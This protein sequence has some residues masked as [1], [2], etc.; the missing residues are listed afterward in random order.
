M[1]K[2]LKVVAVAAA[3]VALVATGLGAVGAIS[4]TTAAAISGIASVVSAVAS[5]GSQ[6][7][8]KPPPTRGSETKIQVGIEPPAPYIMGEAYSAGILRH[9]TA[10][11]ATL[12]KVPNP[13]RAMV[14]VASVAGP[15]A[16]C[17]PMA[18]FAAIG[19]YYTGFLYTDTQLGATPEAT[20]LTPHFAGMP[21]WDS[22][23]KLS[24]QAAILWNL[25][26]DKD[27]K[28]FASGLPN[29]GAVWQGVKVYDPREDS[30]YPGGSGAQRIDDESTWEYS[31]NPALHAIAY[32]YG[33]YQ[34]GKKVFGIGQPVEGIDLARF[35]AWANVCDANEWRLSGTIYEPGD[36]WA[37]LKD[38]MAAGGAEP[39]ATGGV[40]SVRYRAPQTSLATVTED[41]I[42]DDDLSITAMQTY[43]A[44]VNG[45]VPKYR[46]PEHN[47]EFVS[48]EKVSIPTYV[49]EDG[50]EK[51]EERQW[52]LVRDVDQAAQLASYAL[53]DARELGPIE[54]TLKPQ[55]RWV[56]PGVCL[57]LDLPSLD[58]D[59]DAIVLQRE[60]DPATMK[61]KLTLIGETAGKHDYALGLTGTPPP[62]PALGQTA[63]ERDELAAAAGDPVGYVTGLISTSFVTDADPADGLIQGT[64]TSLTVEDHTRSYDDK[65]AAVTGGTLTTEDD[66]TTALAAEVTYHIYYDDP[67]RAGGAVALKATRSSSTAA[68]TPANPYRH[69]VGSLATDVSGGTGTSGGGAAP[70]GWNPGNYNRPE[71]VEP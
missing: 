21:G 47:W 49:T 18:D 43:R 17:T 38:I 54:V 55:W 34:N 22:S 36:R 56:K 63:E 35:V 59:G 67:D 16:A 27:G 48:A 61:V 71:E 3:A 30:T 64:D 33:R 50:E 70:P 26:F 57:A 23:S 44:R 62:T 53:Q 66:G 10:Y 42:A 11:G 19:S 68:T 13:Y 37:N 41:D 2:V 4:L 1:A 24:G 52:N 12:N 15:L 7:L 32:A 46:S 65:T 5:L 51:V 45:I 58:F 29:L 25:L 40:L 39:V 8:T 20:A 60:I 6:L 31:D 14:V 9:D 28:R 69:Y